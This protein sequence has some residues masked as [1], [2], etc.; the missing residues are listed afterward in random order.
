MKKRKRKKFGFFIEEDFDFTFTF[1]K[2]FFV[3][4]KLPNKGCKKEPYFE[5]K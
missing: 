5:Y 2:R 4:F 3:V 1:F